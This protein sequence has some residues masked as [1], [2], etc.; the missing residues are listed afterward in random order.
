MIGLDSFQT[1]FCHPKGTRIVIDRNYGVFFQEALLPP[2]MAGAAAGAPPDEVG[3]EDQFFICMKEDAYGLRRKAPEA[4]GP[5]G[6]F[7]QKTN[8]I[9]RL[10]YVVTDDDISMQRLG[11]TLILQGNRSRPRQVCVV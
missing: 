11:F 7:V 1:P 10:E 5:T 3:S 4:G 2:L 6:T 8:C 9:L